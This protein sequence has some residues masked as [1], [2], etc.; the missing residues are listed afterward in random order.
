[1][2]LVGSRNC[3]PD[4]LGAGRQQQPVVLKLPSVGEHDLTVATMHAAK[5]L[6]WDVVFVIMLCENMFPALRALE[7]HGGEAEERRLFYVAVTRARSELYL[8]CPQARFM[9]GQGGDLYLQPSRFLEEIPRRL[10]DRWK[11]SQFADY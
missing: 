4:R 5:G 11:L 8:C 1:M 2:R 7:S 10:V 6:E 3:K 9:P